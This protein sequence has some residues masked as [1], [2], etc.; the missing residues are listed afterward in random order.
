M[1]D[2]AWRSCSRVLR[3]LLP[4]WPVDTPMLGAKNLGALEFE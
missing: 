4:R 3:V 1:L 2:R